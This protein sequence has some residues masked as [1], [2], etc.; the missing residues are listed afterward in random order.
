MRRVEKD[1]ERA[2]GDGNGL[3]GEGIGV[4]LID[5]VGEDEECSSGREGQEEAKIVGG[6]H[7][8]GRQFSRCIAAR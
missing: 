4:C 7:D 1:V 8:D 5:E 2:V 6:Q 3:S